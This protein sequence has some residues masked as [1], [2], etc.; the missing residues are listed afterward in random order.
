MGY[1]EAPNR[2]ISAA[3]DVDYAYRETGAGEPL[4]LLQH[5]R[6]N[7]DNW[8]PALV[9]ALSGSRHVIAF[10]NAGVGD[11]TGSTPSTVAQMAL[12]A[13]TFLDAM[14]LQPV[15]LLGFSLGSFVAQE[16]ALI[17]P[18]AVRRMVLAASAPQG[19][20]GMHGWAQD[21]I[22]AVGAPQPSPDDY[23]GVFYT[24]SSSSAAAGLESLR[25]M[26]TRTLERDAATTWRTRM[27]QY[28][29]VVTWGIPDHTLLQRV[30]A[31]DVPVLVAAGEGDR[32]ILPRYSHLLGGL[33]PR[34]R[35]RIYPDAAHGFLFQHHE[36]F[37][38][39]V[40]AF[41]TEADEDG[42]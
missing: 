17:R 32:M 12:D 20:T 6:G 25:R 37:A 27:A 26:Y 14:E 36:R 24:S 33:L 38:A 30:T 4:V 9:D 28:D 8:D 21:V 15:D 3:N 16:I 23:L 7:N 31:I 11:S 41:L 34:A 39:D 18:G 42:V 10:D 13:L 19:A 1:A 22:D 5:F 35:V 40:G 2:V 29:A